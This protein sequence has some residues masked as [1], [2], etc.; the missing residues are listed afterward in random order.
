MSEKKI[1]EKNSIISTEE[2]SKINQSQINRLA[3]YEAQKVE[4][5]NMTENDVNDLLE[6]FITYSDYGNIEWDR[7]NYEIFDYNYYKKRFPKFDDDIIEILVKCS[8]KKIYDDTNVYEKPKEYTDE[9]FVL[10]FS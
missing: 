4:F 7:F 9:D 1:L 2:I 5:V 10:K 6:K 3:K 8:T